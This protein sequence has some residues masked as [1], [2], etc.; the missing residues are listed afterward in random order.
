M[1][2]E[3]FDLHTCSLEMKGGLASNIDY[4]Q[5]F[6]RCPKSQYPGKPPAHPGKEFSYSEAMRMTL[7]A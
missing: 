3:V 4:P 2:K 6:V 5:Q 7:K 1:A